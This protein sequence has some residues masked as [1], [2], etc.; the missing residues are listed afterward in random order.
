MID[1]RQVSRRY[2]VGGRVVHALRD[3]DLEIR[4]GDYV[5]IMGPSGSGKSTL[6]NIV[7]CLDRPTAGAYLL[8]GQP[9]D[10]LDEGA[11]SRIRARK[12]GFV[13]QVFHL[14]PR[15]TAAANV[16]LPML[17]AGIDPG[18]RASRVARA[19][20]AVSLSD[21]ALHRPEQLSGGERQRVA[22]ARAIVMG[23]AVLLADEPTGNLDRSSG[24]EIVTLLEAMNA[25]GLTLIVVT[26]DP[27]VGRRARMQLRMDD[28]ALV[29]S[30]TA[31][32]AS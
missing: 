13:F 20:D 1:L 4:G 17:L 14:V 31:K 11:L 16:E 15:L 8:D 2:V 22:I 12:I 6:L 18:V 5:S 29:S 3:I 7:G 19:L 21:R 30:R 27:D 24:T 23:P 25:E 28:G 9:V 32:V 26:H 10:A